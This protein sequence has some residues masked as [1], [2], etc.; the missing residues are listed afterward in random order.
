MAEKLDQSSRRSS[1]AK[2]EKGV[3]R[4]AKI[5]KATLKSASAANE[6]PTLTDDERPAVRT[7]R[8]GRLIHDAGWASVFV[9]AVVAASVA[10]LMVMLVEFNRPEPA[11]DS[12]LQA[13]LQ[14]IEKS[15][16]RMDLL[17]TEIR[18]VDGRF[19]DLDSDFIALRNALA[20]LEVLVEAATNNNENELAVAN[21]ESRFAALTSKIQALRSSVDA[22]LGKG[23][24]ADRQY[25]GG[26][27][28]AVG[29]LRSVIA[30]G[31]PYAGEWDL[32]RAL[33]KS[34][35]QVLSA[36]ERL[37]AY[38][39]QGVPTL[40]E[41]ERQFTPLARSLIRAEAANV[42]SGWWDR[43]LIKLSE[44]VS[45]RPIGPEVTGD[46]A[47]ALTARA[48]ARLVSGNLA[49]AITI[50]AQLDARIGLAGGWLDAARVHLEAES[51]L[52]ELTRQAIALI[53]ERRQVSTS[54]RVSP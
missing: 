45:V 28:L 26:L 39:N 54:E 18:G 15:L 1:K 27:L 17:E 13:R 5:K 42:S 6:K 21:W 19:S 22:G 34:R 50:I 43:T 23:V 31:E 20:D 12:I 16:A 44:V 2:A 3:K 51:S 9:V 8:I 36:L 30:R 53:G 48:E 11:R 41:L 38:R 47:G 29:Q 10:I 32:T 4:V 37:M 46:D 33:A 40:A 7:S 14:V 24:Y 25:D 35:P 49:E 52:D